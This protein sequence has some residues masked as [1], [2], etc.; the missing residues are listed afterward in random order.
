M[1]YLVNEKCFS[2][3]S[4]YHHSETLNS[5]SF[6]S[7]LPGWCPVL[8]VLGCVN[9]VSSQ[10]SILWIY[11]QIMEEK[12]RRIWIDW[13]WSK[14]NLFLVPSLDIHLCVNLF[15][16]LDSFNFQF[17]AMSLLTCEVLCNHNFERRSI[18]KYNYYRSIRNNF[19][20]R[21]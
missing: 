8:C 3:E 21:E 19:L 10:C 5:H 18:N 2:K 11:H 12:K 9:L 1:C 17:C 4:L 15:L 20:M 14:K 6:L 13:T 7:C 16:I